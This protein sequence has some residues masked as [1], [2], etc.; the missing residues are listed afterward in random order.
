MVCVLIIGGGIAGIHVLQELLSRRKEIEDAA[1]GGKLEITL[2]K[3][4]RS[5]WLST[6]GLPFALQGIYDIETTEITKAEEFLK[7]GVDFRTQ[8]EAVELNTDEKSVRLRS[9]EELRYDFLVIATGRTPVLPKAVEDAMNNVKRVH[10]FSNEEDAERIYASMRDA[11]N[12]FVRGRG[13]IAL[14]TAVAFAK[15]GIKNNSSWRSS[16]AFTLY[17]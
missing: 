6:C 12:G 14:Q 16:F 15:R 3:K 5:G 8:T 9:G 4:E 17:A 7:Q 2:L 13:I 1:A 11:K 10:T